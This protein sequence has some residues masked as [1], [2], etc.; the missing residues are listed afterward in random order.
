MMGRALG[1]AANHGKQKQ[2]EREHKGNGGN[3]LG[4]HFPNKY[5]DSFLLKEVECMNKV[6]ENCHY[7]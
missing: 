4:T 7:L 2:V 3:T 6:C 1:V 5:S